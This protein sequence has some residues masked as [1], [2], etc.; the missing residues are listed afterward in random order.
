MPFSDATNIAI[1][2]NEKIVSIPIKFNLGITRKHVLQDLGSSQNEE[3][4][5]NW[6]EQDNLI[7]EFYISEDILYDYGILFESTILNSNLNNPNKQN[8]GGTATK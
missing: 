4:I 6:W 3:I 2:Y 8:L 1:Q 7:S 5:G